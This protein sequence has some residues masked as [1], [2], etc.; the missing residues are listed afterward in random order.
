MD[1][2]R[3]KNRYWVMRHGRSLANRAGIIVSAPA[4]GVSE[5]GLIPEGREQ[6]RRALD[7]HSFRPSTIIRSSDF[8][9]ARETAEIVA[10]VIGAKGYSTSSRLRERYF[11]FWERTSDANY[12]KVWAADE[13]DGEGNVSGVEEPKSVL[14]RMV[15]EVQDI[16]ENHEGEAVILISHGDA[17][18]IL[19]TS[20]A[21]VDPRDHRRVPHLETA[22]IRA[23]KPRR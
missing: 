18:Q 9:R 11:G 20:V 15:A 17:L 3:L 4:T 10:E 14:A 21:G 5:W 22:E 2:V 12:E 6:V 8:L 13:S 19:L 7:G 1:W 16:E 23:L